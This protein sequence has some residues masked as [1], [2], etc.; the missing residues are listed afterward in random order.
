[1]SDSAHAYVAPRT[2][3]DVT[4][5]L[6]EKP[7]IRPIAGGTDL[8]VSARGGKQRLPSSL[9][10]LHRVDELR[11]WRETD[12]ELV[13]GALTSHDLLES[14][15]A[16]KSRWSALADA[17]AMVGSPATRSTGTLG[18]NL[19]NASPAM[20]TG[21]PLLVLDATVEL[22]S[23][24]GV[25]TLTIEELLSGPGRTTA[26]P[27]ELLTDVRLPMP[28]PGSDSAYV[29]LEHRRAMEIAIVGA[30]AAVTLTPDGRVAD[31]SVALTAVAPTCVRVPEV[32]RVLQDRA[33]E[34]DAFAEAAALARAAVRPISDVRAGADYRSAMVAVVVRRALT[35]AVR[36]ARSD[37]PAPPPA[38]HALTG[39]TS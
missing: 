22:R 26:R 37:A 19:M 15:S 6:A 24:S 36:R 3:E 1:M 20:D 34:P 23:S 17:A 14:T 38:Q 21:S 35:A 4:R 27:D 30:A 29:R 5:L 13:L 25:R 9:L 2:V 39:R 11:R 31:A 28:R 10:S 33:P 32:G 18:G 8:V 16:I 12:V 7:D